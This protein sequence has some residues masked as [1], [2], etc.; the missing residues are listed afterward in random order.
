VNLGI[1]TKQLKRILKSFMSITTFYYKISCTLFFFGMA[2]AVSA[3]TASTDPC[4]DVWVATDSKILMFSPEPG[5]VIQPILV[6][7]NG[8][9]SPLIEWTW[10]PAL[11][12]VDKNGNDGSHLLQPYFDV[13]KLGDLGGNA[14][15][16][17]FIISGKAPSIGCNKFAAIDV[18]ILARVK[19]YD[20][21]TPNGDDLNDY[22]AIDNISSYPEA[23]I[24]VIDRWGVSVFEG[25]GE[26]YEER[27]FRGKL[28]GKLLPTGVYMYRIKPNADY[29]D[30]VGSLTIIR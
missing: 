15:K 6:P 29:P 5:E 9:S 27:P 20:A 8:S 26:N 21:I 11:G 16:T 12:M 4:K 18:I 10:T 28:D 19:P 24:T 1:F 13:Q 30:V 22:W 14:F 17:T 25:K 3:Q 7:V 23:T 2:F